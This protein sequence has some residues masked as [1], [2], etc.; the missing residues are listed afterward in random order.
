MKSNLVELYQLDINFNKW[1]ITGLYKSCLFIIM[2]I[3]HICMLIIL[4][5]VNYAS[6]SF[7]SD[8]WARI[9]FIPDKR[10]ALWFPKQHEIM[11]LTAGIK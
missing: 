6:Q 1:P 4:A 7:K 8:R 9:N 10:F 11:F 2:P 3:A 5:A